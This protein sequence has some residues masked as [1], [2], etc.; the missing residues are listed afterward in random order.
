[1]HDNAFRFL[2]LGA[3]RGGT[4][5]L[6]GLLDQHSQL[7]VGFEKF[8][9]ECLMGQK[10]RSQGHQIFHERVKKF[11]ILC[12]EEASHFPDK[13]WGNKITTEQLYGLEDHNNANPEQKIDILDCFFNKYLSDIKVVFILRDGRACV[14]SKVSRTGISLQS[15]CERWNFSVQVY[16]FL[17]EHHNHSICIKFEDL[18][19]HPID[20]LKSL[21]SFLDISY[22]EQML[23]G[24]NNQKIIPEYRHAGFDLSKLKIPDIPQCYN[25]I[26]CEGLKYCKYL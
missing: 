23:R 12:R 1:M 7:E 14:M 26:I 16:K 6:A 9:I 3:G 25:E 15:A 19:R 22:E 8:S 10:I 2:I 18:L 17:K 24:T 13:I 20:I 4:S 5:L 21:C 11:L